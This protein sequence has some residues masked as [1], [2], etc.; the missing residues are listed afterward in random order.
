[1]GRGEGG[2]VYGLKKRSGEAC[3]SLQTARSGSPGASL[4][5]LLL[6]FI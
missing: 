6:E 3:V 4:M 5:F 1:M 2:E